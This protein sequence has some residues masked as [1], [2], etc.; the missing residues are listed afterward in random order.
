[1]ELNG[2]VEL[3]QRRRWN[4]RIFDACVGGTPVAWDAAWEFAEAEAA[5]GG[6]GIAPGIGTREEKLYGLSSNQGTGCSLYHPAPDSCTTWY[7]LK[8]QFGA[9]FRV[10]C[11]TVPPHRGITPYR[12]EG[13]KSHT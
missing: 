8:R 2:T 12:K 5:C 10:S 4:R 11:R 7:R 13:S 6:G 3:V 9:G 1:M